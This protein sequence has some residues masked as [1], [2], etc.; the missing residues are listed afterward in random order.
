[1]RTLIELHYMGGPLFMV[2]LSLLALG[3]LVLILRKSLDLFVNT[4]QPLPALRRGLDAIVQIGGFAFIWGILG[5]TLGLYQAFQA[6]E[7]AGDVSPALLA[8]GLK[9]SMIA[10]IYGLLLFVVA[11]LVWFGLKQR[12]LSLEQSAA[13][14]QP[15]VPEADA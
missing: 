2:P 9:V 12:Y 6:I 10:P 14:H 15:S 5:Q 4:T 1:M 3:L 11:G 8:G 7:A 13:S